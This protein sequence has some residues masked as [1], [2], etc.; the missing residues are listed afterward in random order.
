[1][2]AS[3]CG[4]TP[5]IFLLA[6]RFGI[7]PVLSIPVSMECRDME[8]TLTDNRSQI[9]YSGSSEKKTGFEVSAL[10][11][12]K[13]GDETLPLQHLCTRAVLTKGKIGLQPTDAIDPKAPP[14]LLY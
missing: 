13:P 3:G 4:G 6:A 14:N 10:Q 11:S 2:T 9:F 7:S 8:G 5:L 12:S 1:M